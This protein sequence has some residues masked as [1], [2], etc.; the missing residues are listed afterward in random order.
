MIRSALREALLVLVCG[1]LLALLYGAVFSKGVFAPPPPAPAADD[2][3]P[4]FIDVTEALA[5]AGSASPLFVD[6]RAPFDFGLGHIPGAVN[7]PLK[8]FPA[9]LEALKGVPRDRLLITYCDGEE[10]NSS[11]DLAVK[12]DSVGYTDI[13]IFF[14]GWREWQQAGRA[15]E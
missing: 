7:V 4:Q 10:C 11:I 6:A 13:R 12:L 14:G 15:T 2:T 8:S 1:A 9:S 5:L 3:A